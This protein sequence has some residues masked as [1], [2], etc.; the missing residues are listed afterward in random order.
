MVMA[1]VAQE[2]EDA[3][4]REHETVAQQLRAVGEHRR[5]LEALC[6][7]GGLSPGRLA[8][9]G[10]GDAMAQQLA[11]QPWYRVLYIAQVRERA[12]QAL[13]RLQC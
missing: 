9:A 12:R 2:R 13:L 5:T 7:P 8:A 4:R 1:S 6:A 10:G 3:A 11:Q